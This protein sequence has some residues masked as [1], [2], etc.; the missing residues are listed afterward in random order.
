MFKI[1]KFSKHHSA[2]CEIIPQ[3]KS[4]LL[5][6]HPTQIIFTSSYGFNTIKYDY[7]KEKHIINTIIKT[8]TKQKIKLIQT[9]KKSSRYIFILGMP[10]SGTSLVE[11]ILSSHSDVYGGGEL[12]F[13]EDYLLKNRGSIGLRMSDILTNPNQDKILNFHYY[14]NEKVE[15]LNHD[16][17]F[18]TIWNFDYTKDY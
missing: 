3:L 4:M 11:Q 7:E 5:Y 2:N 14:Y 6:S 9:Y 8:Y 15:Y 12:P 1:I 18:I 17:L 13:I 10:R 16:K